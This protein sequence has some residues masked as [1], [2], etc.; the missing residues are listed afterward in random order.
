MD[1]ASHLLAASVAQVL[2]REN[3]SALCVRQASDAV[4]APGSLRLVG[5]PLRAGEPLDRAARR[6]AEEQAGVHISPEQQEFVGLVH[7]RT[8]GGADRV[9]VVFVS[10]TWAG[11]PRSAELDE[12]E[13]LFWVSME[14]PPPDCHPDTATVFRLLTEGPSYQAVNWTSAGGSS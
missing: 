8:P 12:Q 9:T 1:E 2:L 14:H 6:E 7:H 4:H 13:E 11:E 5:G 10:Q 3:G